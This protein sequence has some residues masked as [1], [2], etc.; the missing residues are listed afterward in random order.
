VNTIAHNENSVVKTIWAAEEGERMANPSHVE[1][2]GE[3]IEGHRDGAILHQP[4][5][6]LGLI[7]GNLHPASHSHSNLGPVELAL[8]ILPVI[9]VL[10]LSLKAAYLQEGLVG[11]LHEAPLAA[12][13]NGVTVHQLLLAQAQQLTVHHS[14][15]TLHVACDTECPAG[16]TVALVLHLRHGPLLSPVEGLGQLDVRDVRWRPVD[17][18]NVVFITN[19]TLGPPAPVP[20]V[21]CLELFDAEVSK[22]V[23]AVPGTPLLTLVQVPNPLHVISEYLVT[24]LELPSVCITFIVI[25]NKFVKGSQVPSGFIRGFI[26]TFPPPGEK[27]K[28]SESFSSRS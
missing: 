19:T 15:L 11:I 21:A 7:L 14:I 8:L 17:V 6:H 9:A 28:S 18:R 2:H 23:D 12:H 5:R 1:L 27:S 4:L 10:L 3:G 16:A 20:Q 13:V 26:S 24:L 25:I 22:V